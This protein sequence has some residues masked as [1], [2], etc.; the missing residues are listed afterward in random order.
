MATFMNM[1]A[2]YIML[3]TVYIH[4]KYVFSTLFYHRISHFSPKYR[5]SIPPK[6][7]V[8]LTSISEQY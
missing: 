1:G 4:Y 8:F 2:K 3:Q 6:G 7:Y 5:F